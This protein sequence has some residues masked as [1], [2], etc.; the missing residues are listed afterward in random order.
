MD[1]LGGK[2]WLRLFGLILA[3]GIAG[4]LIFWLLGAVWYA[5]GAFG[6]L[7]FVFVVIGFFAWLYDRRKIREYEEADA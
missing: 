6:A 5:W 2:F 1:E 4:M 7:L 3:C